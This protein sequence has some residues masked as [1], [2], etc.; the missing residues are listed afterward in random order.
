[1][2]DKAR[3]RCVLFGVTA[4]HTA[5]AFLS[6]QLGYLAESGWDVHL[7]CPDNDMHDVARMAERGGATYHEVSVTRSPNPLGDIKGLARLIKILRRVRPAVVVAGTPKMSLLLLLASSSLRV[8]S[9]LYICHGLRFEG[10]SGPRRHIFV[11]LERVLVQLAHT[12]V[13][14]SPSVR[15][16]LVRAGVSPSRVVVLGPGSANGV[17]LAR[18]AVPSPRDVIAARSTFD[19]P[20]EAPVAAFVGR[21]TADKGIATL[22]RCAQCLPH[23]QFLLAGPEEPSSAD[24]L[25]VIRQLGRQENVRLLGPIADIERVYRAADI[26]LLPTRR[27]GLPTVVLEA[28]AMGV[29]T[30]ATR[31]TGTVDAVSH[32]STGILTPQGD[33]SAFTAAVD[34]II[35]DQRRRKLMGLAAAQSAARFE[36]RGIWERWADFLSAGEYSAVGRQSG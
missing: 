13:A 29:P 24:D 18:F 19:I 8:P 33:D 21:L 26:L 31:A 16:G 32:G 2:S 15:Q 3:R 1:M 11:W 14:V 30:V 36:T 34:E 35:S 27:E 20:V 23:V 28:G 12:T 6:G 25:M 4:A 9:R 10:Y 17:D 5:L 7:A 22:L